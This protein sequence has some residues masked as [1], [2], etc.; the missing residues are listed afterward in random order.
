MNL[1]L[2]KGL[3]ANLLQGSGRIVPVLGWHQAYLD[4]ERADGFLP[5]INDVDYWS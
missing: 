3:L 4:D 1:S 2:M 5:D